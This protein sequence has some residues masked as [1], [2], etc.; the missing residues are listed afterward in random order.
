MMD[1]AA[2]GP[3]VSDRARFRDACQGGLELRP[4]PAFHLFSDPLAATWPLPA[5]I[6]MGTAGLRR[7]IS[8]PAAAA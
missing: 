2:S 6:A 5:T 1:L 3:C 4:A 7:P 8:P